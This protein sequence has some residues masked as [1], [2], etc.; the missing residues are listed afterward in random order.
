MKIKNRSVILDVNNWISIFLDK[1][2]KVIRSFV[3]RGTTILRSQELEKEL[4]EVLRYEKFQW[5]KPIGEYMS[6][7]KRFTLY[8]PTTPI[9][10]DCPDENDNYLFDLAIQSQADYLVSGDR[11]VLTTPIPPPTKVISYTHFREMFL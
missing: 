9:F 10:T 1:D 3:A 5:R 6:F 4:E 2:F 7:F 11:T 8:Y